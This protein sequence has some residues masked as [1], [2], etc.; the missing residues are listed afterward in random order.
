MISELGHSITRPLCSPL[1][2]ASLIQKV[3]L[4]DLMPTSTHKR[5]LI[6]PIRNPIPQGSHDTEIEKQ[7]TRIYF[8]LFV[9]SFAEMAKELIVALYFVVQGFNCWGDKCRYYRM[10]TNMCHTLLC[11]ENSHFFIF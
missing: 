3:W 4:L 7:N 8:F 5:Y 2:S 11:Y 9:D 10:Y 6:Y 1:Y